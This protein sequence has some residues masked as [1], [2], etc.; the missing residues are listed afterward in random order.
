MSVPVTERLERVPL[1]VPDV[2]QAPVTLKVPEKLLPVWVMVPV[3][4][5]DIE[6]LVAEVKVNC[7][8]PPKL[9]VEELFGLL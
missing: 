9:G 1:S 3:A 6:L 2:A 5:R 4:E 8:F 7:Q